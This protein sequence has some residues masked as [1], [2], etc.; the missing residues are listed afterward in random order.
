MGSASAGIGSALPDQTSAT[1]GW[2][3]LTD[4][5]PNG[6]YWASI[7]GA[8]GWTTVGAFGSTPNANGASASGVTLT[9]Q[10]ADA[11]HPGLVSTATQ[12]FGGTKKFSA[13]QSSSTG[14]GNWLLGQTSGY[15]ALWMGTTADAPDGTNYFVLYN[16]A[17][18]QLIINYPTGNACL[19]STGGV[20]IGRWVAGTADWQIGFGQVI[21]VGAGQG[22]VFKSPNG[23]VTKTLTI[24]NAGAA[25]WS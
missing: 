14:T 15:G 4:G 11:T 25:V 19:F 17:G 1:A 20:E 5:T 22:V 9:L 21:L 12:T 24:D 6:A 10:P 18:N 23:L 7:S 8:G 3:L 16:S 13:A 2:G